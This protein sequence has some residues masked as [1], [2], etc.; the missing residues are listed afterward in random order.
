MLTG[1]I[2]VTA[3][4][5]TSACGGGDGFAAE[6]RAEVPRAPATEA[7]ADPAV[8]ANDAL[9]VDLYRELAAADRGDNLVL[10]PY[11][12]PLDRLDP[13]WHPRWGESDPEWP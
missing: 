3:L 4:L 8:A 5:A 1:A 2:V 12:P 10:S 11:S 9:A 7:D 13:R 6:A